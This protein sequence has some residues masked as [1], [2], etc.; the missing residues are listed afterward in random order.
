MA[1]WFLAF[2]CSL[3]AALGFTWRLY[4]EAQVKGWI[5]GATVT[6]AIITQK[7]IDPRRGFRVYEDTYWV[8]WEYGEVRDSW[9][10][11]VRVSPEVWKGMHLGDP[12]EVIHVP[13]EDRPYLRNGMGL[14]WSIFV[15]SVGMLAI[16]VVVFLVSSVRLLWWLVRGFPVQQERSFDWRPGR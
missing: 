3:A 15:P 10:R 8:S 7:G 14:E 9:D 1:K 5:P 2:L 4:T 11:R 16:A 6:P 13:S 12:I